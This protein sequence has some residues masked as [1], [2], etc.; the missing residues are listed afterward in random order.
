MG[1]LMGTQS[2]MRWKWYHQTFDKLNI[3]TNR[4]DSLVHAYPILKDSRDSLLIIS[5]LHDKKSAEFETEKQRIDWVNWSGWFVGIYTWNIIDAIGC[6]NQFK[7]AENPS[8]KRA[9]WLSAIP[10]SGAGQ[11]YNGQ[12]FKGAMFSTVQLGCMYSAIN[13]QRV[14]NNAERIDNELS[15]MPDSAYKRL[16]YGTRQEWKSKAESARESRTMFMWYGVV[17]YLYGLADAAVDAHFHG[18]E[19]R[20][21]ITPAVDPAEG[22]ISLGVNGNIGGRR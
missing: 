18:F 3:T 10:F 22:K 17:F 7:G 4:Y 5:A 21:Q 14:M 11:F 6:S 20:F 12:F 1:W 9:A 13:F 19:K 2:V 15:S 16:D 8:P